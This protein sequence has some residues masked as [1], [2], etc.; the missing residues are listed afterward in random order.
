MTKEELNIKIEKAE[1]DLKELQ[2]ERTRLDTEE[3]ID[4]LVDGEYYRIDGLEPD[5]TIFFKYTSDN[6]QIR[7]GTRTIGYDGMSYVYI[8]EGII[9]TL[10]RFSV[11]IGTF[12][13]K[14]FPASRL[15]GGMFG[16]N[17]KKSSKE[18]IDKLRNDAKADLDRI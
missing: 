6:F 4:T 17:I 8:R 14:T 12:Y 10:H 16:G 1:K 18:D 13:G 9:R 11:D 15:N 5:T 7:D 3:L 2:A